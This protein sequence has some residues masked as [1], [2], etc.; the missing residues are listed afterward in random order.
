MHSFVEAHKLQKQDRD[1]RTLHPNWFLDGNESRN[2]QVGESTRINDVRKEKSVLCRSPT[3]YHYLP[4]EEESEFNG[5][6]MG[7]ASDSLT[8]EWIPTCEC[9]DGGS[10]SPDG[11]HV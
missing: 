11:K 9:L 2:R 4:S 3:P 10:E 7:K 1:N 5:E 8:S 6:K